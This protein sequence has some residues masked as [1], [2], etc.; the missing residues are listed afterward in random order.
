[1]RISRLQAVSQLPFE[2]KSDGKSSNGG[3][4]LEVLPNTVQPASQLPLCCPCLAK[5]DL[6]VI[7]SFIL[8]LSNLPRPHPR[9]SLGLGSC[10]LKRG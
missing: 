7:D 1:M 8:K 9:H 6:L 2:P 5:L 3:S 4:D 10:H